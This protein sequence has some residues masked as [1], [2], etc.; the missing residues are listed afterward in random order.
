M[1]PESPAM[2]SVTRQ[3][4]SDL[5]IKPAG[6]ESPHPQGFPALLDPH[7]GSDFLSVISFSPR[8]VSIV[9]LLLKVGELSCLHD[10]SSQGSGSVRIH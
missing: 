1:A 9:A 4:C 8:R 5:Q 10:E 2:P 7:L 3:D 6:Q